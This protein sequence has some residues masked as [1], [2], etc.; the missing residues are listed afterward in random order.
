MQDKNSKTTIAL[1]LL[2]T[3]FLFSTIEL[4]FQRIN[5]LFNDW[6]GFSTHQLA[7]QCINWLFNASIGFSTHQ[8]AFQRINW[9]FNEFNWLFN[10]SIGFFNASIGFFNASIGFFNASIGFFQFI[11]WLLPESYT[12]FLKK[13]ILQFS[14]KA[15]S[16]I[17]LKSQFFNFQ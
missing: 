10:A 17:F 14:V 8:L 11:T 7:F 5:W 9:L 2:T 12:N 16:S 15:N 4:A 6:I 1:G 13:P 3:I